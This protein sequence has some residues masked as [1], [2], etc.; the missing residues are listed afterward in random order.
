[1]HMHMPPCCVNVPIDIQPLTH[2]GR[3]TPSA[4]E[5]K[6]ISMCTPWN[7]CLQGRQV[8][9]GQAQRQGR[10]GQGKAV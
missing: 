9:Q 10:A 4:L 7:T 6:L 2:Q 1:M 3:P 5:E 8:G